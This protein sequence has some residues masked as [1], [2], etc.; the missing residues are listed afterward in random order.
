MIGFIDSNQLQTYTKMYEPIH[1]ELV[2]FMRSVPEQ[3]R[4]LNDATV[5]SCTQRVS[6]DINKDMKTMQTNLLKT[7]REN[8]KTEVKLA[9]FFKIFNKYLFLHR[10]LFLD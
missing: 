1:T 7:L 8:I 4:A 2:N 3:L 9:T 10:F 6:N 5:N